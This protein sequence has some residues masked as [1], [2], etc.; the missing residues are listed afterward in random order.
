MCQCVA[1][2]W[3]RSCLGRI[4]VVVGTIVSIVTAGGFDG[5]VDLAL[6]DSELST[7]YQ[8]EFLGID[9]QA[10]RSAIRA[11]SRLVA[12]QE[13]PPA[14]PAQLDRRARRDMDTID[15]VLDSRGYY[16]ANA[17]FVIDQSTDPATVFVAVESGPPYPLTSYHAVAKTADG[18]PTVPIE[19]LGLILGA[20]AE[21]D[22]ILAAEPVLLANIKAR[23]Y[24]FAEIA[25]REVIVDHLTPSVTVTVTIE[26]GP[27]SRF[28]DVNIIGLDTVRAAVV[29]DN[30]AWTMGEIY[31]GARVSETIQNLRETQLFDSVR[32]DPQ[33]PLPGREDATMRITLSERPART[34]GAGAGY[35]TSEGPRVKAFWEHR[36]IL[37]DNERLRITGRL[38]QLASGLDGRLTIPKFWSKRQDL[39]L[40]AE[41]TRESTDAFD[42][43]NIIGNVAL[44]RHLT[45]D[46]TVSGGAQVERSFLTENGIESKFTLVSLPLD[47]QYDTSNDRLHPTGGT[48][49]SA[50]VSPYLQAIGSDLSFVSVSL[51]GAN[52]YQVFEQDGIVLAGRWR[53]GSILGLDFDAI[54][55]NKRFFSGGGG[56]VRG[57]QF[58]DIGPRGG[59][60]E[61]AGGRSL[62]E[63]G[64][65]IRFRVFEDFG[66]V[67][68]IEGGQ[69]FVD[70]LPDVLSELQW[71]A[72]LGLRYFTAVGPIRLDVGFPI[73]KRSGI[74]DPFQI[75]IS[76]GQA[77]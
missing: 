35:A 15:Q 32:V 68:F 5:V 4:Y 38:A 44:R 18:I 2:R 31:D 73:N 59:D 71:G 17:T 76:L 22:T 47:A 33:R 52:Y 34:V 74:D 65:E 54:P 36:N 16:G 63:L 60:G 21:A 24:P 39:L 67:P 40:G 62:I 10:L 75:Y 19:E 7:P 37:G 66:I 3:S 64:A 1:K 25:D 61:P 20:P 9:D 14:T 50:T 11:A 55:T 51:S 27:R 58:Q 13:N 23:G 26:P 42:S 43:D 69:V 8:V 56:S 49:L 57:Y 70:E 6:A 46:V 48:R 45:E 77:F 28:G 30:I 12:D 53:V 41:L 72:G 29:E